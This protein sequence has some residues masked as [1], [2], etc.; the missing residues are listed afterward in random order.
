L[1]PQGI[2]QGPA[3]RFGH[4]IRVGMG[5]IN[6]KAGFQNS[7]NKAL[8]PPAIPNLG[9]WIKKQGVMGDQEIATLFQ[10]FFDK[11]IVDIQPDKDPCQGSIRAAAL[12]SAAIVRLLQ[13][14]RKNLVQNPDR[15]VN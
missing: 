12:K 7:M 14:R 13:A 3:H 15:F 11:F 10:G 2:G 6:R 4:G 1:K 5:R 9:E 8:N